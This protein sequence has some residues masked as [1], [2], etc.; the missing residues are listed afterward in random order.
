MRVLNRLANLNEQLQP[1]PRREH[2][3]ERDHVPGEF[4]DMRAV[5]SAVAAGKATPSAVAE[6]ARPAF[7]G[8]WSA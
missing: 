8:D 2:A 3:L 5:L 4:Q 7:P 1:L 6:T